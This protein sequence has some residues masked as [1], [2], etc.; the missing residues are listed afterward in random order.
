MTLDALRRRIS[1]ALGRRIARDGARSPEAPEAT[2]P[3]HTPPVT[4]L[5]LRLRLTA[6]F[7]LILGVVLFSH[8]SISAM[9]EDVRTKI[10]ISEALT[11]AQ[12]GI[13]SIELGLHDLV[14]SSDVWRA[15][16]SRASI[17]SG[18]EQLS[19]AARGIARLR[20]AGAL[21]PRT[22]AILSNPMLRPLE[23]ITV[24]IRL[25]EPLIER[26]GPLGQEAKRYSTLGI[27]ISKVT[28]PALLQMRRDEYAALLKA[29]DDLATESVV[30]VALCF[31]A[32]IFSAAFIFLPLERRVMQSQDV[33][34]RKTQAAELASKSKSQFLATMSHEIR[35]PMNGVLGMAGI[36]RH[37]RLDDKQ[38]KML[39]IITSSGK[40]LVSLLDDILDLSR[41]EAQ[42]TRFDCRPLDMRGVVADCASLFEPLA[43]SKGVA[44]E[45]AVAPEVSALHAGDETRIRQI[46]YNLVSNAI[47][48]THEGRVAISVSA[49]DAR[50]GAQ[51]LAISIEDTGIGIAPEAQARVFDVFEQADSSTTRRFGGTG[52]GLAIVKRLAEGM[53]GGVA[54]ESEPGVGSTF[55][56]RL[57][58][59]VVDSEDAAAEEQTE[60][61]PGAAP[62]MDEPAEAP[63]V[64]VV[65]D[66]DVN[67]EVA[68][69]MLERLGC[70]VT[71]CA[72][73]RA[74]IDLAR[75]FA[76]D[77]ILM[78]IS[79]PG[80]DG[81][82][83][84]RRIRALDL[85][86]KPRIHGMSAH[87][88]PEHVAAAVD[89]G[90]D[91][92]ITKPVDAGSLEAAL[93]ALP[94][95]RSARGAA[96]R[97]VGS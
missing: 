46:I 68:R 16:E 77:L 5:Y 61:A 95:R 35:T 43:S 23:K 4:R 55:T 19:A 32:L 85:R 58:L 59:K 74:A 57:P 66:N 2:P 31:G 9:R 90:M 15:E 65:D 76:P 92:F 88:G 87:V 11:S 8:F 69:A 12:S 27:D 18:R 24:M 26:G 62:D 39:D 14:A 53:G 91:G 7:A 75:A 44:L 10:Q 83:A 50:D 47:K 67:L 45:H 48:F 1:G 37:T 63:R 94:R 56:V 25:A 52:L 38:L 3:R 49:E 41:L 97:G 80:M 73:G 36:L 84:T 20:D 51:T 30:L 79:M 17:R 34:L 78:D 64:L 13:S 54:I 89:A 93:A 6:A 29:T 60:G 71:V 42:A 81:C 22:M 33:I 72:S 21:A 96:K 82:E 40:T 86:R 28:Q 70:S